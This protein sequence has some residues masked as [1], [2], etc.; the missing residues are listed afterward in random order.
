M[1]DESSSSEAAWQEEELSGAA[2]PAKRLARR[3]RCLLDQI[4][5]AGQAMPA[6]TG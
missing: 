4:S 1:R 5:C 2:L 6:A 3:L